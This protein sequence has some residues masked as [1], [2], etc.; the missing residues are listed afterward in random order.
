MFS[1]CLFQPLTELQAIK[2]KRCGFYEKDTIKA[3]DVF[4]EWEFCPSDFNSSDGKYVYFKDGEFNATFLCPECV[5]V[6][7]GEPSNS[8]CYQSEFSILRITIVLVNT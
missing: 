2:C 6:V 7:D 4:D 1:F 3:N 5:S 8:S